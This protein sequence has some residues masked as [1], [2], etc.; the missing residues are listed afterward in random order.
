N[1]GTNVGAIIAP[2]AAILLYEN[3]GWRSAF[4]FTGAVGFLWLIFW[5]SFY[6][7]PENHPRLSA[8]E[9]KGIREGE[10][11]SITEKTAMVKLLKYRQLWAF[12]LGKMLTDPVWWFYLFWLPKF[13]STNYGINGRARIPYLT[14]VYIIADVG[15]VGGGWIAAALIKRG[16][17]LNRARKFSLFIFAFIMPMVTVTYYVHSAWTAVISIGVAARAP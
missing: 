11:E 13:L 4:I 9:F 10:E 17:T 6:E 5:W 16:W 8:E 14:A 7:R 15:S 2:A 12:A 3:F 1:A